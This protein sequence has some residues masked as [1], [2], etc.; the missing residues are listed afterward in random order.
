MRI[1]G[2]NEKS[3]DVN[4][5]ARVFNREYTEQTVIF[6]NKKNKKHST[7]LWSDHFGQNGRM[8][9]LWKEYQLVQ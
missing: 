4:E 3:H 8:E 5:D 7:H 1:E 9:H 2:V 6:E